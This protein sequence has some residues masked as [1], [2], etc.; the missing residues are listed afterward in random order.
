MVLTA[1][2]LLQPSVVTPETRHQL[3]HGHGTTR[4]RLDH[5][6]LVGSTALGAEPPHLAQLARISTTNLALAVGT[7]IAAGVLLDSVGNPSMV[8]STL[9]NAD[10][11]WL[12]VAA[13]L[14]LASNIGFAIGLQGTVSRRLP[15]WPTTELQV[16]MSFSNLAV[17]GIGGLGMQ[18]RYLQRQGIDLSSA[19]AA[20]GLLSTVGNLVAALLLFVAA[21]V[22]KP[23]KVD[24]SL[25]P[26]SGLAELILLVVAVVGILVGLI[27]GIPRIR[28]AVLGPVRRA[29]ATMGSAL[30]SP[31]QLALLIGGNV[32][33]TLI[34]TG[35][36]QA[37][38][39]AF[40]GHVS[41]WPLLAANVGVVTIS[42][43][44]PI[45]GG[46][47]AVGTVGLAAV[48]VAFGVHKDVAVATVLV[49]QLVYFYLPAIPGFFATEHLVHHEYL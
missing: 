25:L 39:V 7:L 41:F 8:W 4:R 13:V 5:L 26:T 35:C 22:V 16:A 46:G 21:L 17:P 11:F 36:L 6:R 31:R 49:N 33:A 15:F 45:P 42:S 10:W 47:N 28:R 38:L 3:G 30:R 20:G 18:V 34:A 12:A 14:S 23:K 44:V 29:A 37:C 24:L 43:I 32:L 27:A 9:R 2:P 48:L 1:F 40:G 19:V